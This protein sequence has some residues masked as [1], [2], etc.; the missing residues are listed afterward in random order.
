MHF[1]RLVVAAVLLPALYLYIMYLPS[2]YF[3]F[4]LIALTIVAM[5]EF[6]SMYCIEGLLK[7]AGL[8]FGIS[9]I[10]SSYLSHNL[11]LDIIIL[12]VIA[13]TGIRLL[14]KRDPRSSLSEISL[15]IFGLLYIPGLLTF[16]AQIRWIGPEW[17]ILLYATVWSADSM[18]YYLGTLTGKKKLYVEISPN[19]TVA[20][21]AGSLIGG[22][23][24]VF[25]VKV[26]LI[27]TLDIATVFFIGITI[28]II[29]V[30]G[31]LVES[32]FKRDAGVKD[33]GIT[34]PGHGGLL[35]K[36]D[37]I[38]FAGPVLL[39]ILIVIGIKTW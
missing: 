33:S 20:G 38:L 1:K 30:V 4:L 36:L 35:D 13:I 21:A 17:I 11:L 31:D 39:W 16:Q 7:Y 28:G 2:T 32:M 37:G 15:P 18:A 5:W 6:Y 24:A 34:I 10:G 23:I 25:V 29:T 26:T 27:P 14:I 8:F 22:T 9:I 19:K 3:L 12:S